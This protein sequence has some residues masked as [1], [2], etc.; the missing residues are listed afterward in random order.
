M[1]K[2]TLRELARRGGT[3]AAQNMTPAERAA[4][5]AKATEAKR[6]KRLGLPPEPSTRWYCLFVG[7]LDGPPE[8]KFADTDKTKVREYARE[9]GI[10]GFIEPVT[11]K[12]SIPIVHKFNPDPAA[13]V[14]A[15]KLAL[16]QPKAGKK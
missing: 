11:Y 9:H 3:T 5:S 12:P 14:E 6:R 16:Q 2:T 4:R 8:L 15:L 13:Q 7:K 10:F 1:D